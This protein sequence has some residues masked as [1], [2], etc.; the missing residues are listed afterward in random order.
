MV[1]GT[2]LRM[3]SEV[4]ASV[5]GESPFTTDHY[6]RDLSGGSD[7]RKRTWSSAGTTSR[8]TLP[9]GGPMGAS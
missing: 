9:Y 4:I 2:F 6:L 7:C 1:K 3:Y 5:Y 8:R